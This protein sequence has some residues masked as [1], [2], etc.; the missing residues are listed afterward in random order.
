M[1][2]ANMDRRQL[3][4]AGSGFSVMLTPHFTFQLLSQH[5]FYWKTP[6]EQKAILIIILMA[7]V[8][9]VVSFVGLLDIRGS[10]HI[11]MVLVSAKDCYEALA[12]AK[13]LALMYSYLKISMN[14]NVVPDEIKG[15]ELHHSFPMT[16]FQGVVLDVLVAMGTVRSHHFWLDTEHVGKALQNI[17]VCAEML[18]FSLLQ[19]YAYNV[20][21]Y[22]GDIVSK[23]QQQRKYE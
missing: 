1:D 6:I 18:I 8:Y 17:L 20:S 11:F 13:F 3:T 2:F 4:L 9:A 14:E 19:Q 22:S 15:R 23:L 7:P 21:P 5:L 10:K 12:V 16:L